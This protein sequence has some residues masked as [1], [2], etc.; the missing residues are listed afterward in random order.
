MIKSAFSVDDETANAEYEATLGVAV[1]LSVWNQ[2]GISPAFLLRVYSS[3]LQVSRDSTELQAVRSLQS[4]PLAAQRATV[5]ND[6]IHRLWLQEIISDDI[7]LLNSEIR[8]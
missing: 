7:C 1:N 8:D 6:Q 3:S 2:A 4:Q 5:H